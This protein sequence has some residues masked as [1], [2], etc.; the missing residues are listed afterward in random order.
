MNKES[1]DW[2]LAR[3]PEATKVG[4]SARQCFKSLCCFSTRN[5]SLA[6]FFAYDNWFGQILTKLSGPDCDFSQLT[7][8]LDM[9]R[10]KVANVVMS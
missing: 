10:E 3:L 5:I 1:H 9:C 4:V 6:R 8:S 2:Q 7:Q